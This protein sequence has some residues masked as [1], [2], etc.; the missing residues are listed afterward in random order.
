M[1]RSLFRLLSTSVLVLSASAFAQKTPIQITADLSDAPRK[2]YHAEIDIPVKPGPVSLTTPKW[3]PG[4]HRP[5]G[6]VDEIT[7]VVFTA[8]GKTL[9]WRRDDQDLYQYHVTVP[10]GVTTL[11]AHLDCIVI[12]RVSQKLAVLEWEK[13]MLYP[14]STPVKDIAIQP[15]V[16]V[17]KGWGIGTA[18]TPTDGPVSQNPDTQHP[19]GASAKQTSTTHFAATT[20]EQLEDSP[21]IAGQYFHEFALAP[22]VTPKHYIDV[23]SDA[24]E[25]SKLRPALLTELN[26]LVRETGAAYDSRHYNV[27][28]FLLTLSDVAGGEGLEHGQSSD[29]G[30]GEKGFSDDAHQLSA[31]ELLPHEFTHSWNGKYRRPFNL[32]QD[33]FA[34]MQQGSLLWTYEGMTQY[35]GNVLAA[36]AGLET[37]AQYRDMLAMSAASLDSRPGRQWRSTE[38]TAIA[39]SIL[40]GG[41]MAW[42][43]WRRGQDYYQEGELF[44]LDADTLIR[45]QTDNKKSLT[46]FLHIFLAKGGNTG[47]L[48]VTYNRDELIADLNQVVKYDWA[49]F[50]RERIDN[51]NPHADLDGIE[52]GGYKLVFTDKPS[53]AERTMASAGGRRGGGINVWYSLGLRV[54]SEGVISDVRWG[55]AADKANLAPGQKII[56]VNG[57]VFSADALRAAIKDAKGKTEPTHLILQSDTFVTLA[58]LDYHDG[59]RYPSLERIPNTPAY[60]DDITTPLTTPEKAPTEKKTATE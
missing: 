37:Q 33:D 41:N 55:S 30:V 46:D 3:I 22:E 25:D 47:P 31:A 36:R 52:R 9:T 18:L 19:T 40:R 11:H 16:T 34:K 7:G 39:A 45:K 58:D 48:I 6:P 1:P 50:M 20:V 29:N 4:N 5:T 43:N 27:Y 26:N 13:L 12:A 2:I 38:D 17:P 32:Y 8:N 14:A 54:S 60:L 35:L 59:E 49:T 53:A 10:A 28:H 56:A 24:P 21:V 44:W 57:N 42:S 15:S 23:V 51:P